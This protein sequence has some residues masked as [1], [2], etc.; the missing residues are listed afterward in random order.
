VSELP[1]PRVSSGNA[2]LDAILNGGFVAQRPYLIVGPVGTGKTKLALQFLCEGASHG[3]NVLL[4]TLEEPPN[5]LRLDNPTLFPALD[6]VYV[7]DAIPDVMR[8]EPIPHI[9]IAEARRAMPFSEVPTALRQSP[10]MTSVEVSFSALE[11]TLKNEFLRQ[12][13]TR[14]V[15]DSLTALEYFNMKGSD[16]MV[17]AQTFLRL[18]SDLGATTLLTVEAPSEEVETVARLL[19]RGSIRLFRWDRDGQTQRAIGVEKFRGSAYD[20]QLHSYTVSPRG[21]E[22]DLKTTISRET[23]PAAPASSGPPAPGRGSTTHLALA[24]AIEIVRV[25]AEIN[26]LAALGGDIAAAQ[27]E[28]D[29]ARAAH[30]ER[31]ADHVPLHL[32]RA[33]ALVHQRV[34][35]LSEPVAGHPL[36]S[37][38]SADE[39]REPLPRVSMGNAGI[40]QA[41]GGGLIPGRPYLVTG[42][43]GSGKTLLGLTFLAEGLQRGEEVLL[44]AVDEPPNEILDNFRSIGWDL[45][46]VQ[47][48]DANPGT[49]L[50]RGKGDVHEG[51]VLSDVHSMAELSEEGPRAV[52]GGEISLQAI[53]SKLRQAMARTK[54]ARVVV[55]SITSIRRLAVRSPGDLQARRTEVQSLL[56]FLSE[57]GATTVVTAMAGDPMVLTPEEILTRGEIQLTR[58]RVG[59]RSIRF[60]KVVRMRG[61]AHDPEWRP[62]AITSSGIF[63]D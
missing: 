9:D 49:R 29:L 44:V 63:C 30:R 13:F 51:R 11:Q 56:R 48:L 54:F 8:Y 2:P 34:A 42:G 12:R 52:A 24:P 47:V 38:P 50:I 19:A 5:E 15:I 39:A 59:D 61:S 31:R 7:L 26:Y 18:L 60:M 40:D 41:L 20:L 37:T 22:I 25:V 14:V 53:H 23:H 43:P 45:S 1:A 62:F 46:R 36:P 6:R 10:G 33:R 27:A 35:E 3:E 57:Q 28:L 55:D 32:D 21:L 4:V 58:A 17:G 16:E